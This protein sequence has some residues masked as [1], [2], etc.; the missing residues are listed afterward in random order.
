MTG[1]ISKAI[2]YA[3]FLV[4]ASA[5]VDE[6]IIFQDRELFEAPLT[7]AQGFL[8]YS[9][10]EDKLTVCGNCHVGVQVEWNE[11]AHSG[12]WAGLEDSGHSQQ[13]CEGCHTTNDLGNA[14]ETPAGYNAAPEERYHDVQC[15]SCHNAGLAHVTNPDADPKPLAMAAVG[16]A[17]EGGCGQCHSGNHHG[18]T[19]DWE[20]SPHATVVS[21]AADREGCTNCHSGEGALTAWGVNADY[22]EK[23]EVGVG[24]GNHLAITC[25]V[26]HDPH[27]SPND[28]QLRFPVSTPDIQTNLCARC[29]NRRTVPDPGSSHGLRPHAP[30]A[31][32]L[33]GDVGWFPPGLEIDR[34]QIVATHGTEQNPSLCATCH[35]NAFTVTD[36]ETG[37]F[38]FNATGHLF[39]AIPCLDG[40]GIPTAE[41]CA[42]D[43]DVRSFAGCAGGG[44]HGSE[45]TAF[46]A[47]ATAT[48][49]MEALVDQLHRM[50]EAVDAN[51]EAPGGVIDATD[52]TF[53]TAEGAFFNMALAEFP[54][55][56]RPDDRLLYAGSA[57]HNPF[58]MEQLLI[59]SISAVRDEYGLLVPPA[60]VLT[61]LLPGN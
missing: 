41:D 19:D 37:D 23:A 18:F 4:V 51:L 17:L 24:T 50:L 52:P 61:P 43:T 1:W 10:Q 55:R 26:C 36:A 59:A 35:V 53:T 16:L 58:L 7:E 29:H 3:A 38:V 31:A 39:K 44:C 48:V 32:L 15:E 49:R 56:D 60:L 2:T 12:A 25:V 13:F 30:E 28:A 27:G 14:L 9:D 20:Q 47:L 46:A 5:C 40:E 6:K 8:G 42:M 34:G 33:E 11:T 22:L 45:T 57:V 54:E 21:F